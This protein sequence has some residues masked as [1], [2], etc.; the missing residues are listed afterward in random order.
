[1]LVV[2]DKAQFIGSPKVEWLLQMND[3]LT[4]S[5]LKDLFLLCLVNSQIAKDLNLAL[6]VKD[7]SLPSFDLTA[8]MHE[9]ID[10]VSSAM[11][12]LALSG[13]SLHGFSRCVDAGKAREVLA[14]SLSV[15]DGKFQILA[16]RL[17]KFI[18]PNFTGV[19]LNEIGLGSS[20][21]GNELLAFNIYLEQEN[22]SDIGRQLAEILTSRAYISKELLEITASHP[23]GMQ[24]LQQ[25]I[26]ALIYM[27]SQLSPGTEESVRKVW[28]SE[29]PHF[30]EVPWNFYESILFSNFS[31]STFFAAI[32][33]PLAES[34]YIPG[35]T[36]S[37]PSSLA[38]TTASF[39]APSSHQYGPRV[40][41]WLK[42]CQSRGY[43]FIL[44]S[45]AG[46][47][48]D[49]PDQ[50]GKGCC[51]VKGTRVLMQD[52]TEKAIE[53]IAENEVVVGR[54]GKLATRSA[55]DVVWS[56]KEDEFLY[57]INEINPFFN[58]SHP[59]LTKDGW[60]AIDPIVA[61]SI[62]PGL[63]VKKLSVGDVVFRV[64]R[65]N[66]IEYEEVLI[67]KLSYVHAGIDNKEIYSLHC[68]SENI[69]YHANGFCVAVSYPVITENTFK[70][71]FSK[72]TAVER[73][74]LRESFSAIQHLLGASLGNFV[75][76]V[77]K[78]SL[79]QE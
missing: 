68:K 76:L 26:N 22:K 11:I 42:R 48:Y 65:I 5:K 16:E 46:L 2:K 33:G 14:V 55:Q 53:L 19:T 27:V 59:F 58:S 37:V 50:G 29:L 77:L 30:S 35:Q 18:F 7:I 4:R 79:D 66:P 24:T 75:H 54:D 47:E 36:I 62:N 17:Y 67:S 25:R 8:E 72:L 21:I 45:D 38:P 31:E 34:N 43:A 13:S 73:K 74:Y 71:A 70:E 6:D 57:G 64:K 69:G 9:W 15:K 56:I 61:N 52:G 12:A 1:M 3:T 49:V 41:S 28:E 32:Q 10:S 51:F 60:K 63:D 20:T 40:V 44:S 23:E 39:Q 78:R